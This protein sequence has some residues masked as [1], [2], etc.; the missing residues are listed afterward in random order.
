MAVT[1]NVQNA[2]TYAETVLKNQRMNVNNQEPGRTAANNVLQTMLSP[3]FIWRQNRSNLSFPVTE[4]NGT[5]YV[6]SVLDMGWIET[7]WIVDAQG[8]KFELKGAQSLPQVQTKRQPTVLAPVYDDNQGSITFRVN[9][10]PDEPYTV[11][12]DYQRAAPVIKSFGTTFAPM[13]DACGYLFNRGVLAE[14]ALLVN[15]SRWEQ[16]KGEWLAGLLATQ[17]GLD[18]QA[19]A[20]FY[21]QMLNAGRTSLRSQ[22]LTQSGTAGRQR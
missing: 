11:F 6:L 19:K 14:C 20:I 8:N 9:S 21:D 5:D 13:P 15:D 18:A 1:L 12:V 2:I 10:I 3:P 16:W 17:D 22:G 4:T 7:Q